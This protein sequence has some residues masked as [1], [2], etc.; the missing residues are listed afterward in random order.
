MIILNNLSEAIWY[1]IFFSFW[2]KFRIRGLANDLNVV[3]ETD[4]K[5]YNK[6]GGPCGQVVEMS[7]YYE[8]FFG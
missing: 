1:V 6:W 5:M 7:S 3:V 4:K 2:N 8:E